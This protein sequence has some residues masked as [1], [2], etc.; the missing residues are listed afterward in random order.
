MDIL[1]SVAGHITRAFRIPKPFNWGYPVFY[2]SL[3]L[4]ISLIILKLMYS[5][6]FQFSSTSLIGCSISVMLI[7]MF[8]FI[9]PSVLI[10]ERS[11]LCIT[12]HYTG[13]GSLILS[14]LSGSALYLV[15]AGLHNLTAALWLRMGGTIVFPAVFYH[16][17]GMNGQTL[18]LEVLIDTIVPAFGFSLF[19][20]GIVWQGFSERNRGAAFILI[21]LLFAAFSFNIMDVAAILVIG[22]WLCLVR[23]RTENIYGP[24]LALIGLRLTG[25][26][27]GGVVGEVDLTTI[28][29]FSD[30]PHTIY[31]ESVPALVV[32]VILM[33]FFRKT[34]G[35]FHAVYSADIYGEDQKKEL[36]GDSEAGFLAGFNLTFVL[37]IVILVVFWILISKGVR[38]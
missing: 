29:V 24:I 15:K 1:K 34:L 5:G 6:A 9:V 10:A 33:A 18:L 11:G 3:G 19:F 2:G 20:L 13:I 38:L 31:Y 35:E 17:E 22:W 16:I 28:R 25:I 8:A 32:A 14:F 7:V 12:G 21:P 23:S 27:I 30:I 36:K 37:G 4:A 26:I